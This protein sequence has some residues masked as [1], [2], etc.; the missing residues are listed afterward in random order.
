M[1][2]LDKIHEYLKDDGYSE[3]EICSFDAS[4]V[5]LATEIAIYAHRGQKRDRNE[6]YVAH[7]YAVMQN[8][9]TFIGIT[10]SYDC[11][12]VDLIYEHELVYDGIQE[13]CLLHDVIEDTEVT[14]Q[15]IKEIFDHFGLKSFFIAHIERPLTLLTHK[16]N[17]PYEEY[18]EKIRSDRSASL[19][20][21]MD[22]TDNM[23]MLLL[24]E[25]G[26]WNLKRQLKYLN[27]FVYI[28]NK[29][30][31]IEHSS[32]YLRAFREKKNK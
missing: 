28:N 4:S 25:L 7:P 31:F 26:D 27:A 21:M 6:D 30:H 20:K 11:I 12:D 15:D 18:L 17:E 3:D 22:L 24:D 19:V 16:E 29:Y 13:L 23:N 10:N 32:A 9:R 5:G 1:E 14:M 8:F 2:M